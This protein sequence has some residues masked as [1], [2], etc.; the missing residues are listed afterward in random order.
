MTA[1]L[2][3]ENVSRQFGGLK[4]VDGVSL[5]IA[6]GEAVA[7][8]YPVAADDMRRSSQVASN[9]CSDATAETVLVRPD[10]EPATAG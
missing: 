3:L 10:P 2:T 1:L 9:T 6:S 4:A 7:A 8:S 5:A